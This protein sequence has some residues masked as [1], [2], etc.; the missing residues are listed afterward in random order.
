MLNGTY[1]NTACF[2]L[3]FNAIKRNAFS[4]VELISRINDLLQGQHLYYWY[5]SMGKT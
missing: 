5:L 2:K 4:L 1:V 3:I